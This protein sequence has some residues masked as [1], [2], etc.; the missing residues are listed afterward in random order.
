MRKLYLLFLFLPFFLVANEETRTASSKVIFHK[1]NLKTAMAKAEKEG[2]HLFVDFYANWCAP[3]K[4]MDEYTFPDPELGK[5][6]NEN[7]ISVKVDIDDFDG[8]AYKGQYNVKLLPTLMVLTCKGKEIGRAET[9]LVPSKLIA[10]LEKNNKQSMLC[11]IPKVEDVR[12]VPPVVPPVTPPADIK[13]EVKP[14]TPT[15]A[16]PRPPVI[17]E[18]VP[19]PKPTVEPMDE[20]KEGLFRFSVQQQPSLGYSIQTG[21]FGEYNN[22]LKE[23]NKLQKIFPK[24]PIIVFI[25]KRDSGPLYKV[26][27]GEFDNRDSANAIKKKIRDIGLPAIVK[28]LAYMN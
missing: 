1:G 9:G 21:A 8:F 27:V 10:F 11:A 23:V 19:N 4:L 24:Q 17:V 25:A 13:P 26:L 14:E 2:K 12:I 3:C 7:F 18:P 28:N 20:F 16:T 6:M 22:V 15:T 5:Y